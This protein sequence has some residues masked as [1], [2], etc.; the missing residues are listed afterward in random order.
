MS[1]VVQCIAECEFLKSK[2]TKLVPDLSEARRAGGC[3]RSSRLCLGLRW[4]IPRGSRDRADCCSRGQVRS[5]SYRKL[6]ECLL[7][8][9][10]TKVFFLWR[11][12]FCWFKH[13]S[14][15]MSYD[16]SCVYAAYVRACRMLVC[17]HVAAQVFMDDAD[18]GK[19]K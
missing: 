17:A 8:A 19:V 2:V 9:K 14:A 13:A 4:E 6:G 10:H 5:R 3:V 18:G 1:N 11:M 15:N 12:C 16:D 7:T